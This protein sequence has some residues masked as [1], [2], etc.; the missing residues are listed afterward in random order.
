MVAGAV[1]RSSNP[2]KN[3]RTWSV[4]LLSAAA[5]AVAGALAVAAAPAGAAI[6][7]VCLARA[8]AAIAGD[9]GVRAGS[10]TTA[11]SMGTNG[12][13]QCTYRAPHASVT[14]NVDSGAQAAWRL[15]RTVVEA[16][17]IFGPMPRGWHPPIGLLGLGPYA[18]WF[19]ELDALMATNGKD[20]LDASVTWR[21]AKRAEMIRLSRAAIT[22]YVRDRHGVG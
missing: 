5:L 21:H 13:P 11:L 7:R 1:I 2:P 16:S 15:M 12:M 17:Q 14:V 4:A 6:P 20:L 9:L 10:V 3:V 22:P 18:S 8:R 19:P